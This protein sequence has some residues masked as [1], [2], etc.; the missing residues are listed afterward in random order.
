MRIL[1]LHVLSGVWRCGQ[2][3][4]GPSKLAD[5][6]SPPLVFPFGPRHAAELYEEIL[7]I[8]RYTSRAFLFLLCITL[9]SMTGCD[10]GDD[11]PLGGADAE[12]SY[13][14]DRDAEAWTV[15]FADLPVDYDPSIYE[16]ESGYR[17]L[18]DG[19][20]GSGIYVQ[21]HNRSDDL[22]MFL[23][24]QVDGLIPEATYVV[25]VS[26]DLAT[27]VPYGG[28][29]HRRLARLQRLR[30]GGRV[31]RRARH[32]GGLDRPPQDDHRQR[33]PGQWR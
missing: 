30:E 18:P 7:L 17:P 33:E 10:D 14:F 26:M 11:A 27:N 31:H 3:F 13:T 25:S 12:F 2:R 4:G 1:W 20:P 22:F 29:W 23:K 9:L 16:I 32:R 24:R 8:Q 15:D 5:D 21:G 28:R 6:G 19:L